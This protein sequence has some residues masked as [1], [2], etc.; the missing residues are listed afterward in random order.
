M[1]RDEIIAAYTTGQRT[2]SWASLSGANLSGANLYEAKNIICA[3]T[4]PRGYR[5]IG[6]KH[7]TTWTIRAG[8]RWF[9]MAE[10]VAHW[11][12]KNNKDALARL[13]VIAA[14]D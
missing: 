7:E 10:A 4:D 5:F 14:H 11:T 3:G 12:A 9:T 2:F 13:A 1:T 8:C 6:V